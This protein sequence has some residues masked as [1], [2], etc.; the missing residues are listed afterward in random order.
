MSVRAD[1]IGPLCTV[2]F[3]IL[4]TLEFPFSSIRI[5]AS[6][7]CATVEA[8]YQCAQYWLEIMYQ[9]RVVDCPSNMDYLLK[10]LTCFAGQGLLYVYVSRINISWTHSHQWS[11]NH[12]WRDHE[13]ML[14]NRSMMPDDPSYHPDCRLIHDVFS[15]I[16]LRI[17]LA[18]IALLEAFN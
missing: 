3:P 6:G 12:R 2:I 14:R 7:P 17:P 10:S 4:R 5:S 18:H 15:E 9:T 8:D 1:T 11:N 16:L 13:R